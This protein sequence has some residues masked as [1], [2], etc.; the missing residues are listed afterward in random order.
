MVGIGSTGTGPRRRRAARR[1]AFAALALAALAVAPVAAGEG[2]PERAEY[3]D[4]LE[5][6]CKPRALETQRVLKGVRE[7]VREERLA[8]AASKFGRG[9]GIF[10]KTV[11]LISAVPPPSPD[12][13]LLEKWF[14]YLSRQ[15]SYLKRI[16]INLRAGRAVKAQRLTA[17]FIHSGNLA[18]DVV[19]AFGFDYCTFKFSRFG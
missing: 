17:R 7:D 5:S 6:I 1:F 3:V 19:I 13:Q 4:H 11:E 2:P 10:G 16:T 8:V 9:A 14:V 15:E 18:N 12:A